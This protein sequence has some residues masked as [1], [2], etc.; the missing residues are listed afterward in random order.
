MPNPNSSQ[1]SSGQQGF[2]P[3]S[4]QADEGYNERSYWEEEVR[5]LML[6]MKTLRDR[7]IALRRGRNGPLRPSD[8]EGL[9]NFQQNMDDL[10]EQLRAAKLNLARSGRGGGSGSGGY[11]GG[12]LSVS[13]SQESGQGGGQSP[14]DMMRWM[15]RFMQRAQGWKSKYGNTSEL[16]GAWSPDDAGGAKA[17]MDPMAVIRSAQPRLQE[18]MNRA[19]GGAA[20]RLGAAGVPLSSSAY[21]KELGKGARKATTDLAEIAN[22]YLFESS[23]SQA[24]RDQEARQSALDRSLSAWGTRGGW[25]MDQGN[26]WEAQFP[27]LLQMFSGMMPGISWR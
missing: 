14:D 15:D 26:E 25:Q 1:P 18:E 27:Q 5:R 6:E 13:Q 23:E 9:H 8:T 11:G 16:P 12:N 2:N 20:Q 19:F 4:W 17:P 3:H 24:A 7:M 10:N 22:K 21:T